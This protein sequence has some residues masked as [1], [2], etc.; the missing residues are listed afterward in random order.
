[1]DLSAFQT[2]IQ[3][4]VKLATGFDNGHVIWANQTR[5]RPTRPFVELAIL[6]DATTNFTEDSATDN[7]APTP[8]PHGSLVL[9]GAGSNY[10]PGLVV[11]AGFGSPTSNF[12]FS[13]VIDGSLSITWNPTFNNG[14]G[15][16]PGWFRLGIPVGYTY[17]QAIAAIN[18]YNPAILTAS[19]ANAGVITESFGDFLK[20]GAWGLDEILLTSKEHVELTIQARCFS[21]DVTGSNVAPNV[22]RKIRRFFARESTTALLDVSSI[23]LVERSPVR[24]ATIVLSTEHEGRG[25]LD[26]KFRVADLDTEATTFIETAT[27]E[28]TVEQTGG[29]VV[30]T[31]TITEG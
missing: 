12:S 2:A 21:S 22:A 30:Q 11:T 19:G 17:T 1:M 20:G 13:I 18:G 9:G 6:E 4:A 7:P 8:P 14:A 15:H 5:D 24:D 28:T 3:S 25:I 10:P 23:A 26:L 27:V 31:L 29:P 16:P